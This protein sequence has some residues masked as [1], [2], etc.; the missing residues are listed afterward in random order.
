MKQPHIQCT[1]EDVA[2]MVI[3]PGD[4]ARVDRVSKY[5]DE[6]EEIAN[7]RE[8][9]SVKGKYKGM[10]V[11]VV[12]TGI[13]GAS[14]CI[15]LEELIACGGE[16]FIRIGSL[17]AYQENIAIGDLIIAEGAVREEGASRMY[18]SENYPA[19]SNMEITLN[20]KKKAVELNYPHHVGLVRS[21][22]SFYID[23]EDEVV[24]YWSKKGVLG[25]DMET[26]ALMTLGRLRKVKV[27][28]ILNNVVLFKNDVKDGINNY[29]DSNNMAEEGEKR[30]IIL[31]LET[32]YEIYKGIR[33]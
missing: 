20:L 14:A 4:P 22:D 3:L 33:K 7:N 9:K 16:Y 15:A 17:G 1:K 24:Q 12:S 32:L 27:G 13:G 23:N 30:E 19:V 28:S 26:S 10:E 29:V 5:L 2:K 11:S 21:H 8:F 25:G 6:Y 18:I 31:A